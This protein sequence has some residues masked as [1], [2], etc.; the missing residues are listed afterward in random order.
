MITSFDVAVAASAVQ[1]FLLLLG[2]M[3]AVPKKE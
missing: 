1:L 3:A 2:V